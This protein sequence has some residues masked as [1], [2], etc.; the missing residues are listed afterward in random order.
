MQHP[1]D[2]TWA[3]I[4]RRG[5]NTHVVL[6]VVSSPSDGDDLIRSLRA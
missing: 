5:D 1:P 3:I 6:F 4:E 2:A